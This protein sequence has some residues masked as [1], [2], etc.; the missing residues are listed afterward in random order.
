M[1]TYAT[2]LTDLY[3]DSEG[4]WTL[5]SSGGGGQQAITNPET[6][7]Y[8]QGVSSVSR[9]PFSSSIRGMVNTIGTTTV[10][11]DDAVWIWVK[12]DV[13]QALATKAA[14]G[15][16]CL[17]GSGTGALEA[18]Y[19]SGNDDAFGGWKCYPIDPTI[20]GNTQIGTPSGVFSDFGARWNVP[21]SGPSKGFPFKVDAIRH[22][23]FMQA[24]GSAPDATFDAAASWQGDLTRQWGQFQSQNGTYLWQGGFQIGTTA[25][26]CTFTDAN[27]A[28]FVAAT[29]FVS[30]GFN[31]MEINNASTVATLTSIS[32]SA[33]GTV[34]RGDFVVVDNA[35]V[36]LDSCTFVNMGIFTFNGGANANIVTGCTFR[37]CNLIT[38]GGATFTGCTIAS[39]NASTALSVD[40]ISIITDCTFISDGT[41]HA[42]DL[43]TISATQTLVWDNTLTSSVSE[44]SGSAGTTVGVSG[45]ANDAILVNVAASQTLTIS[46]ASGATIPTI[47][48]TGTGTVTITAG[49]VTTTV[50]VV[51]ID[52]GLPIEN[53]NV[54]LVAATGGP[55]P[56]GTVII[57]TMTLTNASGVV[58]DTR[59]LA[60]SQPV[61][62]RVRRA[63]AGF[64]TLYKTAPIVGTISSVSGLD[65]TVQ[66]IK[67]E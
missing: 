31:R 33:L 39:S 23:R 21:A 67:D 9:N 61:T 12:A 57:G 60:S 49:Q 7:D 24:T 37:S 38:Q 42:V 48:N 41:G 11:T 20:T 63:S 1:A 64:G 6:D 27:R 51:D 50:T 28:I 36:S 45:T 2:D 5:I 8:I 56:Q 30:S 55:L 13:A 53:A 65:V 66:M 46:V 43:G 59:S 17:I 35:T 58:T 10:A 22:G 18:Y 40:D 52:D 25:T 4:T 47:R 19:V 44:W 32:I 29:E 62:G 26:S 54:Y 3:T 14:G 15:I 34:S 16:Q